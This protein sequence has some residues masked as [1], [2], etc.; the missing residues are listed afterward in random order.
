MVV[1]VDIDGERLGPIAERARNFLVTVDDS[2]EAKLAM[3]F[4]AGRAAHVEGGGIILFHAIAPGDFQH[5]M[6]VAERMRE[7]AWDEAKA[8]L[9]DLAAKLYAYSGVK[10]E[11]VLREGEPKEALLDFIKER[12]DLFALILASSPSGE[13]GPLV[14]YFSGPLIAGLPCPVVILPGT[15]EPEAIDRM[16]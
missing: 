3:R 5:W 6:A 8:M 4:A 9:E 2:E 13:P 15:L 7:E 10:P 16:V 1:N 12:D 14:E 11:I